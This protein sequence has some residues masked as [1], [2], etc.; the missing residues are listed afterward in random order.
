MKN[1]KS[2]AL[3]KRMIAHG[4]SFKN[5]TSMN[6]AKVV[7]AKGSGTA[8]GWGHK[9]AFNKVFEGLKKRK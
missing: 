6:Q 3:K 5:R 9:E 8:V 2:K 4:S 7:T 1:S